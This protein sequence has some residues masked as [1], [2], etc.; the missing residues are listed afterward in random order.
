MVEEADDRE[1]HEDDK[2][3]FEEDELEDGSEEGKESGDQSEEPVEKRI[4]L[5]NV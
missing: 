3:K 4:R 2:K 1:V 5:G